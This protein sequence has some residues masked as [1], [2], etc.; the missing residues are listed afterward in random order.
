MKSDGM[1]YTLSDIFEINSNRINEGHPVVQFCSA[2]Q[3][4]VPLEG[5]KY[6]TVRDA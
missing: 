4:K 1:N 5:L 3:A 6:R 2:L